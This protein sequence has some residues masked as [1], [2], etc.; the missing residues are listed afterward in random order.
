MSARPVEK[1]SCDKQLDTL[2]L[3]L[4]ILQIFLKLPVKSDV[5]PSD[6]LSQFFFNH[7]CCKELQRIV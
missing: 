5:A 3:Y 4:K 6:A 1:V 7:W 2:S